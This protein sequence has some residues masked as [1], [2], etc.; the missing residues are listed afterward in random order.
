MGRRGPKRKLAA[1]DRLDG[2]PSRRSMQT[3][4]VE[5]LGTVFVPEHLSV[6]ARACIE[7]ILQS[8][9]ESVYCAL[10]SFHLAAFAMAWAVHNRAAQEIS[11]PAFEWITTND[12][13]NQAPSPWIKIMNQQATI[14][15]SLGDRLG[16]DPKSRAAIAPAGHKPA[17]KFEGLLMGAGAASH[18][19]RKN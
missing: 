13:G 5:G 15:A 9:P 11:D 18:L 4:G 14:I 16:L 19:S 17:S 3:S 1:L 12:K 6:D 10:D 2:N 8:M 7:V